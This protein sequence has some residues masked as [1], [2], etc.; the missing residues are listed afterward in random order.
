MK[1]LIF[2]LTDNRRHF[3]F[4]KFVKMLDKSQNKNNWKL[5]ILTHTND[6]DFYREILNTTNIHYHA[7]NVT[8]DNN[9]LVKANTACSYAEQHNFPYVMKCDND[10]FLKSNTLDYMIDNLH[11]L[12]NSRHLTIGPVLTSGIPGIEYFKEQ[13]LDDDAQKRI[14]TLFLQTNFYDRD[15]ACYNFLNKHTLDAQEWKKEDFFE[16]LKKMDHHYKGLHPIRVNEK[17]LRFLNNYIIANKHR[18]MENNEL[19]MIENDNSPYLCNS[20]FCIKTDTYRNI[21]SNQSLYVDGYDEVPLNK[22]CWQNNM[23]HLFVKN[24]YAIHMYYNWSSNH[25][26]KEKKF[27]D[28]F[29]DNLEV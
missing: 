27:C 29:F 14:E 17:S 4:P 15:G 22:Y 25:M 7:I 24:G 10:L 6:T 2:Y 12:E 11:L 13:F 16:S 28:S 23:N 1:L 9:Y 20:I 3:T 5:L 19:S 26:D 18:F 21:I 8:Q